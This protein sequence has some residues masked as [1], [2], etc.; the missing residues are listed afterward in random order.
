MHVIL[1]AKAVWAVVNDADVVEKER[2]AS[3]MARKS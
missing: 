3:I 1:S 2:S